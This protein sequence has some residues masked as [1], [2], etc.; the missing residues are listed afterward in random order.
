MATSYGKNLKIS[1]YGGSHDGEIGVRASGLPEGFAFVPCELSE[2]MARRA[3]GR[4]SF[5]TPRKEADQ[6]I[7]NSGAELLEDGKMRISGEELH[8]VIKNTSQRSSDY[9]NLS[10]VPRPSHADFAAKMKYGNNVDLR[11][12]GH[13]SGRLTAPMCIIGGICLQYLRSRGI[14]IAAHLYSIGGVADTPFDLATVSE[15]DFALLSSRSDFPVL[16]EEAGDK[17]KQ[18]IEEARENGDSVGGVIECAILGLPAGLGEHMFDGVENRISGIIFGIPAVK[19]IEFGNGFDCA[20]LFGSENNDPFITDGERIYTKT[21][22]CGGILGGMTNGM[23]LVFRGAMKPT[24]SIFKEQDSVDM[25]S[26]QPVKLSIKGRHD[27]CV[28]LRALPVFEAAAAIAVCDML[29]DCP[30]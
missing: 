15:K 22:N 23:P 10:F 26:M 13:F 17:M 30:N 5:S 2:F 21:N 25:V 28:V 9:S 8:A 4:N 7:F 29:L 1:I 20:S 6:P 11:G 19:A 27:P 12:G 24:P 3:P 18:R 14:K 16:N